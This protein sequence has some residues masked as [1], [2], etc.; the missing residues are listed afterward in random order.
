LIAAFVSHREELR[1]HFR[2]RAVS[3]KTKLKGVSENM[4]RFMR[5]ASFG[6]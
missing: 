3:R 5:R 2:H 4:S 6:E 1:N